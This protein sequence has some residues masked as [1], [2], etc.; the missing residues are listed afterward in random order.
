MRRP[1][2]EPGR[3]A[4]PGS[5]V[6]RAAQLPKPGGGSAANNNNTHANGTP[7]ISAVFRDF[8][9]VLCLLPSRVERKRERHKEAGAGAEGS[10][11]RAGW[12]FQKMSNI[13]NA[14]AQIGATSITIDARSRTPPTGLVL[15]PLE[16]FIFLSQL[17]EHFFRFRNQIIKFK[18][19][20]ETTFKERFRV[21]FLV[22]FD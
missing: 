17:R 21:D 13:Y 20:W 19:I 15:A 4:L 5:L 14:T 12:H 2:D 16:E 7:T 6:K 3:F 18:N 1:G 8:S 10:D 9:F 22:V 11:R